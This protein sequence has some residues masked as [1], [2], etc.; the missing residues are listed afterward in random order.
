M[1]GFM[2]ISAAFA[3]VALVAIAIAIIILARVG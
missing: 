3:S 2:I 1:S